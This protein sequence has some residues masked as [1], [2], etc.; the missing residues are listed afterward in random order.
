[1]AIRI[2]TKNESD[3]MQLAQKWD[4]LGPY[5]RSYGSGSLAYSTLQPGLEY[6]IDESRG[7]CA[8]RSFHHGVLA[9]RGMKC[10]LAD[11]ISDPADHAFFVRETKQLHPYLA[12]LQVSRNFALALESQGLRVNQMGIDTDIPLENF[13]IRGNARSSLRQWRNKCAREGVT[14]EEKPIAEMDFAEVLEVSN[15]WLQRKGNREIRLLTR[16]LSSEINPD[17]RYFWIRHRGK[18]AGMS[19][20]DPMYSNNRIVG[21]YHNFDRTLHNVPHGAPAFAVMH[22]IRVF[23]GEG[24]P[25]LSL[26][27]SP[28]CG[29]SD[30]LTHNQ[31]LPPIFRFMHRYC[32]FI[33]PFRGNEQH[34]R[35]YAGVP[36]PLYFSTTHGNTLWDVLAIFKA[37]GLY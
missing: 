36:R 3:R 11:P 7:Y 6:L 24:V 18:L 4:L 30:D 22:A 10:V 1:L 20:Y 37:L 33:Y 13:S 14:V 28:F 19:I 32:E 5:L 21:Y 29:L 2:I 34:K 25:L 26:G 35:K 17:V 23:R 15:S 27:I 16:P 8:F 12:Y 9:P 31:H